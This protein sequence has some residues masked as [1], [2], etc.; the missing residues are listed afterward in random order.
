MKYQHILQ[1]YENSL[2]FI[3]RQRGFHSTDYAKG[4]Y[5][6]MRMFMRSE[7]LECEDL[8][9]IDHT[10]NTF[11]YRGTEYKVEFDDY[12]Q[13]LY[14]DLGDNIIIPGGSFNSN[15]ELEWIERLNDVIDAGI[16]PW[17]NE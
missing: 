3:N 4:M 16:Y 1:D 5:R 12:G 15:P 6:M 14:L 2:S 13:Q 11:S 7:F 10:N 9:V 8:P 17:L